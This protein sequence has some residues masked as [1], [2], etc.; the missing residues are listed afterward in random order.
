MTAGDCVALVGS[1]GAG[2]TTL[3]NLLPRFFDVTAGRVMIN[4]RDLR[5]YRIPSL[6]RHIGLVTQ[7]TILF[8]ET[9]HNNIA[10]GCPGATREAVV[11]AAR[12]ANAHVFIEQMG[13]AYDT[14]IGEQ[15]TRLSGGQAQRIAIARALLRNPPILI[16]DEATSALDTES[17]RLVQEALDELMSGRTVFVI[18]HRLSTIQHADK[19][20]VLERGRVAETGTHG[21]LISRDGLYRYFHDMQFGQG[22]G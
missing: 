5:E 4:G 16:L 13:Q 18:A 7:N 1:S 8:N 21:E 6:R 14:V 15:G 19:I 10:Y 3:V 17:E 9:V 2:K 20:V 22:R 11:D 12:R